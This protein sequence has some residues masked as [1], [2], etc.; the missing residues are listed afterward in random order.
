MCLK[1]FNYLLYETLTL[2]RQE[3]IDAAKHS[4][5]VHNSKTGE[6]SYSFLDK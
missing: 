2:M 5:N 4:E 1:K 3:I 6:S